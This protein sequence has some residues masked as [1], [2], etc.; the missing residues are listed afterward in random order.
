MELDRSKLD[1]FC[2]LKP[3]KLTLHNSD[4]TVILRL[5]ISLVVL[6]VKRESIILGFKAKRMSPLYSITSMRNKNLARSS[7]I[8]TIEPLLL[9]PIWSS[10]ER[11][12][13]INKQKPTSIW[14]MNMTLR[15][16]WMVN[17]ESQAKNLWISAIEL[18]LTS[19]LWIPRAKVS[20]LISKWVSPVQNQRG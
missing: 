15:L 6:C 8:L 18:R 13:S 14:S 17:L 3:P 10:R 7:I 19:T 16:I 20:R 2:C 9:L 5:R 11:S 12:K 1:H 4:L